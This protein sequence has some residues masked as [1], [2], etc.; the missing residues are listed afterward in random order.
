MIAKQRS[1]V[2]ES[3]AI[4]LL[5][6]TGDACRQL[7]SLM[8]SHSP[9]P[10]LDEATLKAREP[11]RTGGDPSVTHKAATGGSDAAAASS[12]VKQI[13]GLGDGLI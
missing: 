4:E 13:R 8:M 12:S 11:V 3:R 2:T 10:E 9:Q 6:H 5:F 1:H 7:V